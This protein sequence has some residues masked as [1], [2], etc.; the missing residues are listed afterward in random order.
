MTATV[1]ARVDL[2]GRFVR[3]SPLTEADLDELYD[4]IGS[5]QVFASGYG[6][7]PAGLPGDAAAFREFARDYYHWGERGIAYAIRLEGGAGAGRI[8]G[9]STLGDFEPVNEA[10]HL[11]WTAYDP[12]VWGTVVNPEAKLLLLGNA[13]DHGFGRVK[14]QADAV[15]ERSRAAILRLGATFEGVLRRV[16]PKPDG[17]W[18][19]TAVYSVLADEWPSVRAGLEERIAAWGDRP[20]ELAVEHIR[21][22]KSTPSSS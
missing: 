15:N 4:A 21:P 16:M 20:V 14:L 10:A 8:V 1:P 17:T 6:G 12:R 18:R 7:G 13:F 3:L 2:V 5:A 19:D 22:G 11:G 9:T